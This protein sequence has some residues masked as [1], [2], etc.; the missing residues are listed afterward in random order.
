MH[1]SM[2]K[3]TLM[4]AI[5]MIVSCSSTSNSDD[6]NPDGIKLMS[7][8]PSSS[9]AKSF[10]QTFNAK[11]YKSTGATGTPLLTLNDQGKFFGGGNIIDEVLTFN[12]FNTTHQVFAMKADDG[13]YVGFIMT[14]ST[15]W[16]TKVPYT[17]VTDINWTVSD[18]NTSEYGK[19]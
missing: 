14:D 3:F 12:A 2:S 1:K 16:S 9:T 19:K 11:G 4:T 15:L 7:V 13:R 5:I 18:E 10:Y 8:D 6:S 17:S